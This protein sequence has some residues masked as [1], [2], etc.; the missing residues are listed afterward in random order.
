ML[1]ITRYP[2]KNSKVRNALNA[3][4]APVP[5]KQFVSD[6]GITAMSLKAGVSR[7]QPTDGSKVALGY[8]PDNTHVVYR[9]AAGGSI[10]GD[11]TESASV[12]DTEAATQQ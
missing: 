4:T 3:L 8:L 12:P 5:V 11:P 10:V 1:T 2:P 9:I 6:H 7:Y